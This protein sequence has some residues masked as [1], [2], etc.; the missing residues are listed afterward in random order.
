VELDNNSLQAEEGD[1]DSSKSDDE[2]I[3]FTASVSPTPSE[4]GTVQGIE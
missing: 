2:G 1:H 3:M 4:E